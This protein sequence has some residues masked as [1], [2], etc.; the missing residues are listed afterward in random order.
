MPAFLA[1]LDAVRVVLRT[2]FFALFVALS[3]VCLID[4]LVR[5]RR[6]NA[7]SPVAR[8]FRQSVEPL[9]APVEARI[10]RAG[11]VP[12]NAPWWALAAVVVIGIIVLSLFDFLRVQVA[13]F[14]LASQ[15]GTRGVVRMLLSAAFGVLRIA[16]IVRV[17]ISW[18]RISPYSRWVRWAFTLSEPILRPLRQVIPTIGMIDI[19]PIVA[20]LLLGLLEGF[21]VGLA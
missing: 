5:T 18:V 21:V 3:L 14:Y 20:Y 15:T 17:V 8:F 19:T 6:I 4:W 13:E 2:G 9:M 7:F 12:T 1:A 11:G 10:V 16:I